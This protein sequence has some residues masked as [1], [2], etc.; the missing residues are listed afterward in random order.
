[1]ETRV[2]P[3]L[4]NGGLGTRAKST[5]SGNPTP[6]L[7]VCVTSGETPPRYRFHVDSEDK[8]FYH[9]D[10]LQEQVV[11]AVAKNFSKGEGVPIDNDATKK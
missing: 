5:A 10:H 9:L 7:L 1:M 6:I 4:S 8:D 2:P 3:T 11:V